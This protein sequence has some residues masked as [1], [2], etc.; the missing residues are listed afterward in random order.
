[1]IDLSSINNIYLFA[2]AADFRKGIV[3]LSGLI[4]VSYPNIT[5]RLDNLFIFCN[6]ARNQI[7]ILHFR[8]TTLQKVV[9]GHISINQMERIYQLLQEVLRVESVSLLHQQIAEK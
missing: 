1:M 2:G 7:K 8:L 5:D 3:G 4:L 6:S 9:L